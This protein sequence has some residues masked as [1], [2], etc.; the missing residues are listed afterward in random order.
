MV[1][2]EVDNKLLMIQ[3]NNKHHCGWSKN[4]MF[5]L[6]SESFDSEL[7]DREDMLVVIVNS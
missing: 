2:L 6:K 5:S 4:Q 7:E 3:T 1:I